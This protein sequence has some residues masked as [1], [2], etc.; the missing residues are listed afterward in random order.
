MATNRKIKITTAVLAV[1]LCMYKNTNKKILRFSTSAVLLYMK[2]VT[3]IYLSDLVGAC[4]A[5]VL[6]QVVPAFEE[7]PRVVV[8][9]IQYSPVVRIEFFRTLHEKKKKNTMN[10]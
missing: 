5:V 9:A 1:L 3:S 2:T 4:R 8:V 6:L 10:I 7:S